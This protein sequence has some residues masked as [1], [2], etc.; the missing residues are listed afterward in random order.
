SEVQGS[1]FIRMMVKDEPMV[2]AQIAEAFG[3]NDVSLDSVIQKQIEN[4]GM[5]EI[6]LITHEVKEDDIQKT[7]KKFAD[8]ACVDS[9]VSM[10]RVIG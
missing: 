10:I 9:V 8:M 2:L 7:M 4:S 5:S 1:Y 3:K 6:V